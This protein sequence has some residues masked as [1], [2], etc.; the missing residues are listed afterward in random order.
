MYQVG[1]FSTGRG[2]GSRGLLTAVQD[3]I[4]EGKLRAA[5]SFVFC[6]R[7]PGE[8]PGSDQ[9]IRLAKSYGLPLVCFSSRRFRRDL[10][11]RAPDEWRLQYDREVMQRL[12]AEGLR[13]D[14]CVLAGYMLVVGS[15]MCRRYR[16]V[17][18]HPAA[19]GGP[20]G[21]WQEVIWQLIE[22]KAISTGA[23]MHLV[24]PELDQGPPVAYCTFSLRGGP[25]DRRW[26]EIEGL[27]VEQVK[28]RDGEEN[29][30]FKLVRQR[31]V[32]R[33]HPL[34]ISTINAFSRGKVRIEGATV[35]DRTGKPI[36]GYDLTKEIDR[37]VN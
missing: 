11:A 13:Q 16:M 30:L 26:K 9:F 28:A 19:P 36:P 31:G 34:V 5:I 37:L 14:L 17:N 32:V 25:F 1:W 23:M 2:P 8:A 10:K 6:S 15:E 7:E 18:L 24:T 21:A 29:A 22:Q 33:E 12:E 35:V 20:K 3:R 27:T 4:R